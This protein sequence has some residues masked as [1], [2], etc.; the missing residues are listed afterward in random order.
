MQQ[1]RPSIYTPELAAEILSRLASGESMNSICRDD[2]MPSRQCVYEW[3]IHNREGFGDKYARARDSG[4]D[5]MAE[6]LLDIADD[7]TNDYV[8]KESQ[9]TGTTFVA[10]D[11][12][13]VQRSRLRVDTRKWYLSKLAPKRYGDKQ[14]V[15]H[16]GAGGG[17]IVVL[18]DEEKA[19]RVV[20]LLDAARSRA[21]DGSD[22]A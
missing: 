12:E 22:L 10:L 20:Q 13:H 8:E 9:R 6:E 5:V 18:G 19:A 2:H 21:T 14:T 1:G 3:V 16:T 7:G 17:P 15:E 11:A 4:L